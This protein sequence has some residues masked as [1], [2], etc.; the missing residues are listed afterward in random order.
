MSNLQTYYQFKLNFQ[1]VDQQT[2]GQWLI[3]GNKRH[4]QSNIQGDCPGAE[5]SKELC[6]CKNVVKLFCASVSRSTKVTSYSNEN[7]LVRYMTIC[8][9]CDDWFVCMSLCGPT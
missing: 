3:H 1:K 9:I 5:T 4:F 6:I 8:Y 2:G 7:V